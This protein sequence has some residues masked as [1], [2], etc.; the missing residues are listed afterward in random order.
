[1]QT[2]RGKYNVA[3]VMIDEIDE[4]TSGQIHQ[5]VNHPAFVGEPIVIMPDTHFGKG[6]VIGF[7]MPLGDFLIPNVVGVDI[8]CGIDAYQ[9][10]GVE[11]IDYPALD[12]FIRKHVPLGFAVHDRAL[13]RNFERLSPDFKGVA[14]E[15]RELASD[16]E[17][18]VGRVM[19]S[20]G[21]L[22]GGNHF[23][24]IDYSENCDGFGTFWLVVHTGSRNFG[25]QIAK[26]HQAKAAKYLKKQH[27]GADA[28][29]HAEWFP[30][31][32]GGEEYLEDM[33]TAQQFAAVNRELIARKIQQDFFDDDGGGDI[34]IKTVHNFIGSD[35]I[36][37]KGAVAAYPYQRLVIPL[38]QR[39]GTIFATGKGNR[40]WNFSAPH[41]AGRLMGRN[42]A[43]RTLSLDEFKAQMEGVYTTSVSEQ[44][45][46]E[47]PGAY[48]NAD[49]ILSTV[50]ATID[51]DFIGKPTY[52]LKA[53]GRR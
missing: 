44:T 43:K 23:I 2:I 26:R 32:E 25:Y 11:E 45:L 15:V 3:H 16:M 28:Y 37:R 39:D 53:E 51:V 8:G 38:N 20:F 17:L 1:V 18:D 29:K 34:T 27:P 30:L 9:L 52:N 5:M 10:G 50:G 47:A 48:K 21:T 24:E 13:G 12:K 4:A 41:G 31:D 49:L 46:D 7:T 6:S 14:E 42:E 35:D 33:R 19:K 22:G 40:A 36:I